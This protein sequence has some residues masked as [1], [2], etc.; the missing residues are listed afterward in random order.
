[1]THP[2]L[3]VGTK[4]YQTRKDPADLSVN[5]ELT[6]T[7]VLTTKFE[8]DNG[9]TWK[10]E[11]IQY[12]GPDH[13]KY[14]H[15]DGPWDEAGYSRFSTHV[16][17]V[18]LKPVPEWRILNEAEWKLECDAAHEE[19]VDVEK[20]ILREKLNDNNVVVVARDLLEEGR[21]SFGSTR[22]LEQLRSVLTD[23]E[24]DRYVQALEYLLCNAVQAR[25]DT[26]RR[27]SSLASNLTDAVTDLR[28]P[29]SIW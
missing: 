26:I 9:K 5:I 16:P 12:T 7:K 21:G 3:S 19:R 22:A 13:G 23:E 14:T 11:R 18:N 15:P 27:M 25:H 28:R 1:M 2:T 4:V 10:L 6:V 17:M 8:T 20:A 24:Q 29:I